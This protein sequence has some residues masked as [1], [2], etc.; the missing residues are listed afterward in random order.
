MPV[1]KR[2]SVMNSGRPIAAQSFSHSASV[3]AA[4]TISLPSPAGKVS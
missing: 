4:T 2:G 3:S 1:A